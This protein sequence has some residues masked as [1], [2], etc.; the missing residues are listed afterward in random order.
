MPISLEDEALARAN[1]TRSATSMPGVGGYG[2]T[3]QTDAQNLAVASAMERADQ[4]NGAQPSAGF[5]PSQ[6]VDSL[7]ASRNV[8][9]MIGNAIEARRQVLAEAI[10]NHTD[11]DAPAMFPSPK[12]MQSVLQE[13]NVVNNAAHQHAIET[14]HDT[15]QEFLRQNSINS[16]ND[17][18]GL[19]HD[20]NGIKSPIGSR[21]H[22]QEAST[23]FE[24]HPLGLQTAAGRQVA[25][26]HATIHDTAAALGSNRFYETRESALA[27][28][29]GATVEQDA[30]TG[31][32]WRVTNFKES[33]DAVT[34]QT[35][36]NAASVRVGAFDDKHVFQGHSEGKVVQ[37]D[38]GETTK[39]GKPIIKYLPIDRYLKLGGGLAPAEQAA[40]QNTPAATVVPANATP[41]IDLNALAQKALNDPKA[42]ENVKAAARKRLGQ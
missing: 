24:N 38:T 4:F 1:T 40:Q 37:I 36:Q 8:P 5:Q 34:P 23:I 11:P 42:P 10:Q 39:A 28:N 2:S 16:A 13:F 19:V 7:R 29:P 31:G 18:T 26:S 33:A 41:A 21:E 3:P 27:Q 9:D 14:A 35:I 17:F 30:R 12:R 22:A 6:T 20:L 32:K 25:H 15:H